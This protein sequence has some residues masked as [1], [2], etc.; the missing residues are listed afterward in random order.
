GLPFTSILA[1]LH[2]RP[3]RD[4]PLWTISPENGTDGPKSC[5]GI[6]AATD[7]GWLAS[8]CRIRRSRPARL[9][10]IRTCRV[11]LALCAVADPGANGDLAGADHRCADFREFPLSPHL[12]R[13]LARRRAGI[14]RQHR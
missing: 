2:R 5:T 8:L 12:H 10:A 1:V 13:R 7:P 14:F 11:S 3:V 4:I 6:L 9:P